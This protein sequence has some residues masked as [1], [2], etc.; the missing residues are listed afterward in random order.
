M[1]L[2]RRLAAFSGL[3]LVV[4]LTGHA[5]VG[6]VPAV[7]TNQWAAG[8][9]LTQARAG[10]AATS[11]GDGN[12][13]VTGGRG[14]AGPLASVE[15]LTSGGTTVAVAPMSV[16]RVDH[17][18]ALAEDGL[19][20]IAGGTTVVATEE[21]T[22]EVVT[23]SVEIFDV[24]AS[25][26]YP[27]GGLS[28]PRTGA[29]AVTLPEGRV[30]IVGG[31]DA[32]G[33]VLEIEIYDRAAG[34]FVP[35]GA[36]QPRDG[37]AIASTRDGHIVVVG[38]SVNGTAQ[39]TADIIDP[40]GGTVAT[41]MLTSPR[42][43]ATATTTVE[44][45]IL[46][47]GGSDGTTTLATTE[48]LDPVTG[49]AASGAPLGTARADHRAY[50]LPHN[51]GVLL[52]GGSNAAG[53]V[54]VSELVIPWVN[55]VQATPPVADPR[56]KTAGAAGPQDGVFVVTGGS[57]AAGEPS[58]SSDY[59]GFATVKTDKDDY[60]PGTFVT[61]TGNGWQPG[62]TVNLT[63]H[64]V[65]TGAPDTPLNAIAD[66][67][68]NIFNDFWA[69]NESHLGVRFYLTATGAG[70]TAQTTFTDNTN[71][72][73]VAVGAQ[74]PGPVSPGNS[75]NYAVTIRFAGSGTCTAALS[76]STALPAGAAYSFSPASFTRTSTAEVT[77]TLT[78][79]TAAATP[80]GST[81]FTVRATGTAGDCG[82]VS[83]TGA[84]T[85]SVTAPADI[86]APQFTLPPDMTLEATSLAGAVATFAASAT[87]NVD[88]AIAVT[89]APPSGST[90]S[91]GTTAVNC[92]ATD[93]AGNTANGS[94]NVTVR[95][96]TA[97]VVTVPSDVT[98]EATGAAGAVVTFSASATDVVSGGLTPTC[99][100][101]SG[102]TF[103]LGT[104]SV[105]CSATDAAGNPGSASFNVKVQDTTAPVLQSVPAAFSA[106]ATGPGGAVATYTV[107]T[108]TDVVDTAVAVACVP[109]SG[110]AFPVGPTTVIC[111]ATDD[112]GNNSQA[113]FVVTV[114][115]TT[116]PVLTLPAAM[117]SE[118]TG[119]TGAAVSFTAT[120]DDIVDGA[121]AVVCV[122]AADSIFPL[123]QTTVNCSATD[124][125][126]NPAT[127]SFAVTVVDTTPPVVTVPADITLEAT[128]PAGAVATF[129][130]T[131]TDLVNGG[132]T[133]TCLPASGSTFALG[134]SPVN[135]TATDAAGNVGSA[136]FNVKVQDTTAPV[137]QNVPAAVSVEA[138]GQGGAVATYTDPT[139]TDVVDTSVTVACLPSS[140]TTV[141]LGPTTVICTATDDAGNSSHAD[142]VVTVVDTTAPT[143]AIVIAGG[144][145][146]ANATTV[147]L[148]LACSD[149]AT[150]CAEMQFSQDGTTYSAFEPFGVS[151]S[152]ALAGPD[153][154][155]TIHVKFRDGAGN[156]SGAFSDTIVLD[157]TAPVITIAVPA[158]PGAYALNQVI[159]SI[160]SCSDVTSGVASCVG[161]VANGAHLDT[162]PVGSHTFTVNATDLAGNTSTN[163]HTYGINYVF[164]GFFSPVNNG[165]WNV[166]N[167]G[168]AI[169]LKWQLTDALGNFVLDLATVQSIYFFQVPCSSETIAL[170]MEGLAD[171]AGS[172]DL[173]IVGTEYHFNWK[174]LKNFANKCF[175]LRVTLNDSTPAHV[176]KFKFTK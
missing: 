72:Q 43:G 153:G 4:C 3:G 110:S 84:G 172:S 176:A 55:A 164:T 51:G 57:T 80:A 48:L 74:S 138:T 8:P 114:V 68:G 28:H 128:G 66:E 81:S 23:G 94:F 50:L 168:R 61:I 173:R 14:A 26:W 88:G 79:S 95:D 1:K 111:T 137:L 139:A 122:P 156:V 105:N 83:R 40:I 149:V 157:T 115:D 12:V 10:A 175:E 101:A 39:A 108:A 119:P 117:T 87:D 67:Q 27:V 165:V 22:A 174:T 125:A 52:V 42:T 36:S 70:A 13:L 60:A 78:I 58:P 107:P 112:A 106:E 75:A 166:V 25:V 129:V 37:A 86:T 76:I 32:D 65:G 45:Q 19:V 140:G 155:K 54:S 29:T 102:S 141:P 9:A 82:S 35:G 90:F 147:T 171:D 142:F 63:L 44:D 97:P 7:A 49:N 96:T 120:A 131:A 33:P 91:I 59:F 41:V 127:G 145:T 130:A 126:G 71:L 124:A 135:C 31:H 103:P 169:P 167:A 2:P 158:S 21:G 20:L 100:P 15:L 162:S 38:G 69:P 92:S 121:V 16:A 152:I 73:S 98:A 99:L 5:L 89:C 150:G 118:A 133:P 34:G 17:A 64:E 85:L 11:I 47:A 170:P 163:T 113:E 143:G 30:A 18:A 77:A 46:I 136:T 161:P 154:T 6:S 144:A 159:G 104:T 62:E 109:P 146:F 24:A 148:T 160:Y 56:S 134:T 151:K 93:A 116:P 53:L 132:L 123:G